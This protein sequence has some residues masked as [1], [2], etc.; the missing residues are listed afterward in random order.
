MSQ[1]FV[2][3]CWALHI[4]DNDEKGRETIASRIIDLARSGML[5]AETLRD[6]I[7]LESKAVA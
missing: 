3:A 5:K 6:R 1:A 7:I 2:E 4:S